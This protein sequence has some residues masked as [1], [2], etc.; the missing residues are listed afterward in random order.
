MTE[1]VKKGDVLTALYMADAIT[2]KGIEILNAMPAEDVYAKVPQNEGNAF[3]GE[4]PKVVV[5]KPTNADRIR[6]MSDEELAECFMSERTVPHCPPIDLS[7]YAPCD[8][9]SCVECWVEWLKKEVEE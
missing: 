9:I 7:K 2:V 6:Q 1:Y 8:D 4:K 3:N 5:G